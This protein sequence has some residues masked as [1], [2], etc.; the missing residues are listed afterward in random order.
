[1]AKPSSTLIITIVSG[2]FTVAIVAAISFM[3]GAWVWFLDLLSRFLGYLQN[4]SE[5]P[6]WSLHLL[7]IFS[8]LWLVGIVL[9]IG[10][11]FRSDD[12]G[13]S[14]YLEDRF[15]GAIWRW[16]YVNGKPVNIWAYR[17]Q[18]D[19]ELI[20]SHQRDVGETNTMLICETCDR[21]VLTQS[22]DK[23]YLIAKVY[24]QIERK[25]RTGE[26][27]CTVQ[28]TNNNGSNVRPWKATVIP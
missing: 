28:N 10:T 27:S 9:K 23:N 8:V 14:S 21:S 1:M 19:T 2:V 12:P 3:P 11:V 20:Y 26:W 22:G 7:A 5:L 6:N 4:T 17:P 13:I 16:E 18:C 15:F 24:R 25:L